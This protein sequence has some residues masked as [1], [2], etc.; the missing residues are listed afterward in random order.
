MNTWTPITCKDI[1]MTNVADQDMKPSDLPVVQ[2]LNQRITFDLLAV[3][4]DGFSQ[5]K[6]LETQYSDS[7]STRSSAG[8]RIGSNLPFLGIRLGGNMSESEKDSQNQL[9]KQELVHTPSSLFAKLR[10]ELYGRHLVN[11]I[12]NPESLANITEGNFVEFQA[13]L[14]GIQVVEILQALELL[15]SFGETFDDDSNK[16]PRTGKGPKARRNNASQQQNKTLQQIKAISKAIQRDGSRDL[17]ARV[18][19]MSPILTVEDDCFTDPS[20]NDVLDGKFRVFGKVTR[21]ITDES[22]SINL[23]RMSPLGRFPKVVDEFVQ[24]MLTAGDLGFEGGVPETSISGPT[25]QVIPIAI[26]A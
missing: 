20:M 24:A 4:E 16:S 2:Y 8:G 23:L 3:L 15:M 21:V 26:F 9:E 22:E 1:S 5:F 10:S 25:F 14:H 6:T 13:T 19:T 17:V 7:S 11:H 12:R 18:G